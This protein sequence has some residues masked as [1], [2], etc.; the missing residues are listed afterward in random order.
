[1]KAVFVIFLG[2]LAFIGV[3]TIGQKTLNITSRNS[4]TTSD[5]Q[6]SVEVTSK[7]SVFE[8]ET[9]QAGYY[10][11]P[12][13]ATLNKGDILK[14]TLMLKTDK[15]TLSA[16]AVRLLLALEEGLSLKVSDAS[17]D[18]EGIQ[19]NTDSQIKDGGFSF[20][21]NEVEINAGEKRG[22]IDLAIVNLSPEGFSAQGE[23]GVAS[24]D[25]VAE[26]AGTLT[27][28]FDTNLTK[29]VNKQGKEILLNLRGG[30]YFVK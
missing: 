3:A 25:L 8:I 15:L 23:Y 1:M 11:T 17:N 12:E 27:L 6:E 18:K 24:V 2:I 21:V 10:I 16:G 28:E 13:E 4:Q 9:G 5:I 22:K 26:S 30:K 29:L 14:L 19:A 7:T 20:P